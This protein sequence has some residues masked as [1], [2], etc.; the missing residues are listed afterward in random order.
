MA[1]DTAHP[2]MVF[3][4][5][6]YT[7]DALFTVGETIDGY[8]PV[9]ILD[10][11]GAYELAE[12]TIRVL[13]NHELGNAVGNEYEVSDG[14]GGTFTLTGA[15]VSYFDVNTTTFQ[16]EA[17]GLAY[18]TIYDGNGEVATDNTFLQDGF[19][20]LSRF[21]SSALIE[22]EQFGK[23]KGLID[24]IYFTGEEDGGSF[25]PV[26]GAEWALDVAT[27]EL[28]QVP[29]MGRGAWEN[30]TEIDT[31]TK[32]HVAFILADDSSPFDADGDDTDEAAPA[33]LYVGEKNPEGNFLE[34]NG[35]SGGKLYVWVSDTQE[36]SPLD[37]NG[38]GALNGTWV[39][40]DNSQN[41]E[42]ASEDGSTGYDEYGY[43]T[44]RNLFT[45]AETLGAFGFSRPED[46]A[47]NPSDGTEI[48][49]AST[50]VDT[51][52]IDDATGN[53]VDTF[54]T[55]YT[56]KTD[57]TDIDNPTASLTI[58]YDGDADSK[59]ALRSPDNLDWAD[60][61]FIYVQEDK[62]EDDTASGDEVLFGDGA[63]NPNEAGIVKIDPETGKVRRIA[64]IDRNVVVDPSIDKPKKAVDLLADTVGGWESSGILDVSTLFGQKPGSLFLF[65]VQAHGIA[66]QTDVNLD[67]RINDDDLVEG[68]QLLFLSKGGLKL[69]GGDD[70]D[71]LIGLNSDDAILGKNGDDTLYGEAGNDTLN[72]GNDNDK[73]DGGDGNDVIIGGRGNDVVKTGKGR[74]QIVIESSKEGKDKCLDFEEGRDTIVLGADNFRQV[75]ITEKSGN[76]LIGFDGAN[77]LLLKGVSAD[78]LDQKDF[79]FV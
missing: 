44:Q 38:S 15:R 69:E 3:G 22:A 12:N 55:I 64:N 18:T 8:T 21:C 77:V 57:F 5:G 39:E 74:D 53:G 76:A 2:S 65:D 33:Y 45:Q 58:L 11:I 47:T 13:V 43:P 66:D 67:S 31:G 19:T 72:G 17:S 6:N 28:W 26:G 49:L 73:I 75:E 54:G 34:R 25:N 62:A 51:Y 59:R 56:I 63:V 40:L 29:A 68:G 16:I 27:G 78:G 46:V 52:A 42:E 10:G 37:F 41:L 36:T 32:T 9:G 50:G 24:T 61:G 14:S 71:T 1:F 70:D 20:G 23:N 4:L 79:K 35:L 7:A 60:D 30:V 48:V